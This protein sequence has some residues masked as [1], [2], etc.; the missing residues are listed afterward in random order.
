MRKGARPFFTQ[1][2]AALDTIA[3]K[4]HIAAPRRGATLDRT[5]T[6]PPPPRLL[7]CTTLDDDVDNAD[8]DNALIVVRFIAPCGVR[9]TVAARL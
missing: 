4:G 3:H 9:V 2:L 5:L 1:F 8:A 7:P 6:A